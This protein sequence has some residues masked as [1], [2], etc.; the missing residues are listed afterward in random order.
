MNNSKPTDDN[1]CFSGGAVG[2]DLYWGNIALMNN[3]NVI[4][5]S[6]EDH[7]TTAPKDTVLKLSEEELN[8]ATAS[9]KEAA[10]HLK[11]SPP[12][13]KFVRN[14]IH[15]NYFQVKYTERVYA[16]STIADTGKQVNGGTGWAVQMAILKELPVYVFCQKRNHWYHYNYELNKFERHT[17]PK[18]HG[19]WT[20]I[21]SKDL[22]ENGKKAID[23]IFK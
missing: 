11:K 4:H 19:L 16:V 22:R 13:Q 23:D 17:P 18:P 10:K 8:E 6:F 2:A 7:R 5:F 15:R 1:I 21:G 20:G 12:I 3:H 9:I 14:L